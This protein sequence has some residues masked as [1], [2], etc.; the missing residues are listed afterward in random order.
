MATNILSGDYFRYIFTGVF[1][2][3]SMTLVHP[4]GLE[5]I[6]LGKQINSAYDELAPVFTPDGKTLYFCREGHPEN[7]GYASLKD[8]QDIWVS[9]RDASGAWQKPE[10]LQAM[11]NSPY[12][13]FPVGISADGDT[14]YIGNHY[15][16]DGRVMP[17]V[18]KTRKTITGFENPQALKIKDYYNSANLVNYHMTPDEKTLIL[19][20]KRADSK[21]SMDLYVS[22]KQPNN[23][24]SAPL[25]LGNINS[26]ADE[27]TPFLAADTKTIY[28]SS[29][30]GSGMGG[31]DMYVARR[32]DDTWQNW[33]SPENLGPEINTAGSDISYVIDPGGNY[34][35]FSSETPGNGKDLYMIKLP[36]KYRPQKTV[37]VS[38]SVKTRAGEPVSTGVKYHALKDK[39]QTGILQTDPMTGRFKLVLPVDDS[40]VFKASSDNYLPQQKQLNLK[41]FKENEASVDLVLS[42]AQAGAK[43]VL[44]NI[45]FAYNSSKL[46]KASFEELNQLLNLMKKNP[47]MKVSIE[48]HTDNIGSH[49]FNDKLSL[50]RATA[51]K[52]YLVKSGVSAGRIEVK[53]HG[54]RKPLD[55]NK[56]REG[57]KKNRRVEFKILAND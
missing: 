11:F 51:V 2:L 12:Y 57:R 44:E 40:Y 9:Q 24:W 52:N 31:F 23:N 56:T 22:F 48:G 1:F 20:L 6:S 26:A 30:R 5:K 54:E 25:N 38:G 34:A 15:L 46:L 35:V 19:N 39:N 17:G 33:S 7:R 36:E 41:G 53:G 29:N 8:D 32:Q 3:L 28:F 16:P 43:I 55:S 49:A 13:D 14:L 27:V 4:A 50:E 10:R 37:L 45:F 21:N 47:K 18:S 42:K